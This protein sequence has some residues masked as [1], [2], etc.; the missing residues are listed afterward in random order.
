M[1]ATV[2]ALTRA[3]AG[4]LEVVFTG[5][6]WFGDQR[7]YFEDRWGTHVWTLLVPPSLPFVRTEEG[8]VAKTWFQLCSHMATGIFL[9]LQA[10]SS[11][12]T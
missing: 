5:Q 2:L 10:L 1:N 12:A 4:S 3:I 9:P 11:L 8:W 7:G 6:V